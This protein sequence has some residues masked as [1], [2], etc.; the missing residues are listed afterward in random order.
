MKKFNTGGTADSADKGANVGGTLGS[1]IMAKGGEVGEKKEMKLYRIETL[2][3]GNKDVLTDKEDNLYIYEKG[4]LYNT[5][6]GDKKGTSFRMSNINLTIF[7]YK[8]FAK[9]GGIG[10]LVKEIEVVALSQSGTRGYEIYDT[11][12]NR[13][14]INTDGSY[15][16]DDGEISEIIGEKNMDAFYDGKD[17]FKP[18]KKLNFDIFAQG[19][20]LADTAE[21]F[22]ETD[23]MSYKK[24]GGVEWDKDSDSIRT[25]LGEFR[26]LISPQMQKGYYDVY[27]SANKKEIGKKYDVYGIAN[28]KDIALEMISNSN[29]FKTGGATKG[30]NYS[31][32]GL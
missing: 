13:R 3:K 11:M 28:A 23:A 17:K 19:G 7:P 25:E 5:E 31:I 2:A 14:A 24:G 16:F 20:S 15:E 10:S 9:G 4:I 26:V 12:T 30:F 8:E 21:S 1:S 32:G 22:P 27:V 29:K 18:K 6:D